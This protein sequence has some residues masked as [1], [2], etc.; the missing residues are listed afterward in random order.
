MKKHR[1][2]LFR[3]LGLPFKHF[4]VKRLT[5]LKNKRIILCIIMVGCFLLKNF[6]LNGARGKGIIA[7][8]GMN[9]EANKRQNRLIILCWFLPLGT[10]ISYSLSALFAAVGVPFQY[11]FLFGAAMLLIAG[12]I[13]FFSYG[14]CLTKDKSILEEDVQPAKAKTTMHT[15]DFTENVLVTISVLCVFAVI[16]NLMKDGLNTWLPTILKDSFHLNDSSSLIFT[17]VLPLFGV[18]GATV[19][20]LANKKIKNFIILDS[21]LIVVGGAFCAVSLGLLTANVA[22]LLAV[23]C[24]I[25]FLLVSA[26]NNVIT[27]MAPLY[28]R[29][30]INSGLLAG[31]LNGFCY[32]GSTLSSYGLGYVAQHSGWSGVFK[33]LIAL[34]IFVAIVC[35]GYAISLIVRRKEA[36]RLDEEQLAREERAKHM[37]E[38]EEWA[39]NGVHSADVRK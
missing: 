35:A 6:T 4:Y 38:Q 16:T 7:Q 3:F 9:A 20:M 21:V 31:I 33:L 15:K 26:S 34:A 10:L 27:S 13:W 12:A 29:G 25:I 39:D 32:V 23:T 22:I 30:K 1:R 37:E 8:K 5:F 24:G 28:L 19:A 11:S 18:L 36:A 2:R 14:R 17:L